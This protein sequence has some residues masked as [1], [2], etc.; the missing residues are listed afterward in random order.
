MIMLCLAIRSKECKSMII[1]LDDD[2]KFIEADLPPFRSTDGWGGAKARAYSKGV[3]AAEFDDSQCQ[4]VQLP[5][6][7]VSAKEYCFKNSGRQTILAMIAG[8]F[9]T[10]V[11]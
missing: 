5:H 10:W 6:D 9:C 11:R 1:D 7:F 8:F 2:W 4:T 3:P